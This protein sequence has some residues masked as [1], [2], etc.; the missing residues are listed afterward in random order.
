MIEGVER[1]VTSYL[2]I[3]WR[4]KRV[5]VLLQ[6]LERVHPQLGPLTDIDSLVAPI[7]AAL[8]GQTC[9]RHAR[10]ENWQVYFVLSLEALYAE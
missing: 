1:W 4:Q 3:S 6:E 7:M 9:I 10:T 2:G 8:V 5:Y